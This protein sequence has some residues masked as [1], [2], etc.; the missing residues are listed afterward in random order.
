MNNMLKSKDIL[1]FSPSD[2]WGMNP[3]CTTHLMRQLSVNNRV[4]YV[5]PFSSDFLGAVGSP[6][7]RRGLL[8]R[9][10]RKLKSLVKIYSKVNS[11]FYVISPFFL[12]LQGI[13]CFDRMNNFLITLQLKLICKFL[14]VRNPVIWVENLRAADIIDCFKGV[15][16]V[17]HVSDLFSNDSYT[18][19]ES[20]L[21]CRERSILSKSHVVI[22]VSESLYGRMVKCH[23][24]VRYLPHG[25]DFDLFQRA[26]KAGHE[27]EELRGVPRPIV[28][29]FGTLTSHNDI[30]LLEYCAINM[31]SVSFVF[32]GMITGGNYETLKKMPNVLFLGK[33]PYEKIPLLCAS[34]NV[35]LLPWVVD[36]WIQNCNPLKMFE[37]MSCGKPVVS[38]DILEAKKYPE[39]VCVAHSKEE[40]K[41]G[42]EKYL[43]IDNPK[44]VQSRMDIASRHSWAF[45]CEQIS[46]LIQP[47]L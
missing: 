16:T 28:G 7:S 20:G 39:L 46:D 42:I 36:E 25:V 33:L 6:G 13:S 8:S 34:I 32:A 19:N 27:M 41:N 30:E 11:S 9:V 5:N 21:Q 31:P 14:G 37:Y 4:I 10:I 40:F 38:V 24:N 47:F 29:Y 18:N 23:K 45:H 2:W 26:L 22:C 1:C 43:M 3:S 35:G 44:W 12:P 15:C 17:F